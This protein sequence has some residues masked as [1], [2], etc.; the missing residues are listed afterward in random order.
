MIALAGEAPADGE[1][2]GSGDEIGALELARRA[3]ATDVGTATVERLERAV[4]SL[5]IAYPFAAPAVLLRRVR[6]QLGDVTTLLE[7]RKTP[8]EHRRLLTVGSWLSVLAAACMTDL[9]QRDAAIAHLATAAQLAREAGHPELLAWCLETR[10]GQVLVNSDYRQARAVAQAAQRSAPRNSSAHIQATAQEVSSGESSFEG[11]PVADHPGCGTGAPGHRPEGNGMR[12]CPGRDGSVV[13]FRGGVAD[14][15]LDHLVHHTHPLG[16]RQAV[17]VHDGGELAGAL[18]DR[19]K[20]LLLGHN[21]IVEFGVQPAQ[22]GQLDER[23]HRP[24]GLPVDQRDRHTAAGHDV[25]R[26]HVAVTDDL[27]RAAQVPAVPGEPDRIRRRAERRGGPVQVA[28][29]GAKR[30]GA[31]QAPGSRLAEGELPVDKRQ[32][33]PAVAIPARAS[34][35][36]RS[37]KAHLLKMAQQR[38]NRWRPWSALTDHHAAAAVDLRPAT[39]FQAD[40]VIV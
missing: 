23:I 39:A 7:A 22:L 38:M 8:G 30:S 19:G 37:G 14:G 25:P 35:P 26:G 29:Q 1:D 9:G 34:Q 31:I 10:A 32:H 3:A 36:W 16:G 40:Q 2:G 18:S 21:V 27:D 5:A 12:G 4:D 33:L 17:A 20:V 11:A 28:E 6:A 13:G 24:G 15:D